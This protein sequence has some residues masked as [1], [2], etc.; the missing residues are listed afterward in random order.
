VRGEGGEKIVFQK[1]ANKNL[2][3]LPLPLKNINMSCQH[4]IS[5]IHSAQ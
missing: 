3:F 2:L 5:A 1:T 4:T